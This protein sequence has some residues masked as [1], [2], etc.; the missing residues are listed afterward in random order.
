MCCASH[1]Q[2][3]KHLTNAILF[4]CKVLQNNA[5]AG[6]HVFRL[7]QSFLESDFVQCNQLLLFILLIH[8]SYST[9]PFR[10]S[11]AQSRPWCLYCEV[12]KI[13]KYHLA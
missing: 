5:S 2:G 12:A 1:E 10:Y 8:I 3:A 9:L 13:C 11:V 6:F 7:K 4:K